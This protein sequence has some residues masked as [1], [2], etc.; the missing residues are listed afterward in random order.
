[1]KPAVR[2]I[3]AKPESRDLGLGELWAHRELLAWFGWRDLAVRYR[4]TAGG[5]LWAFLQP[6]AT[7]ALFSVTL[8]YLARVPSD[9][10]PYAVL[11]LSGLVPWTLIGATLGATASSIVG[12]AALM[13]KVYFPRSIM[14]LSATLAPMVDYLIALVVLAITLGI[15]GIVPKATALALPF[16]GIALVLT[17]LGPG[18]WLAT[19]NVRFRDVRFV[20]PFLLQIGL[21]GSPV[22]YPISLVPSWLWN[23]YILNPAVFPIEAFRALLLGSGTVTAGMFISWFLFVVVTIPTGLWYLRAEERLFADTI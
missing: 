13:T 14:V 7:M 23:I 10:L 16:L 5:V 9:N 21:F 20:I 18:L 17:A 6:V 19:L 1:M 2:R 22:V 3:T 15:Y 11:V 8:G 12:N 4:Q